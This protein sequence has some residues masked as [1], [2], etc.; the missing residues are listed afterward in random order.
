MYLVL[1]TTFVSA[2]SEGKSCSKAG[3]IAGTKKN[4]LVCKKVGMKLVW[5]KVVV[6]K[7]TTVVPSTTTTTTV[8]VPSDSVARKVYDLVVAAMTSSVTSASSIEFVSEVARY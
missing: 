3:A 6:A 2:T 5:R 4:P 7:T 1:P 8:A